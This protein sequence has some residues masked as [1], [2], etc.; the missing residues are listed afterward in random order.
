MHEWVPIVLSFCLGACWRPPISRSI[1]VALAAIGIVL[2]GSVAF[3][4]SGEINLNWAYLLLDL[5]Q[6]SLGFFAGIAMLRAVRRA[7]GLRKAK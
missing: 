4:I 1:S 6:A 2:I 3:V 5:I 7:P